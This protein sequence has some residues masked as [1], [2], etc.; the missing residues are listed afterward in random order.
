L[1]TGFV[2]ELIEILVSQSLSG[3]DPFLRGVFEGTSH[4]VHKQ[5]IFAIEQL[6]KKGAYLAPGC[7]F[8]QRQSFVLLHVEL[9]IHF[10]HFLLA[11]SSQYL[12]DLFELIDLR[13]SHEGRGSIDHFDQNAS[14]GPHI[15]LGGVVGRSKDEFG[16]AVA[17]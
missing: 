13:I 10:P 15:D 14:G 8:D 16:C 5:R 4:Q 12:D 3:G 9:F 6:C 11:G 1:V 7:P 17:S 2:A